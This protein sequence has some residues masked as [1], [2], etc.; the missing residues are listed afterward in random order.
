MN[1]KKILVI[2]DSEDVRDFCETLLADKYDLTSVSSAKKGLEKIKNQT[3]DAILLDLRI[4]TEDGLEILPEIKKL[5]P[6]IPV[7]MMTSFTSSFYQQEA[8]NLGA[9]DYLVKPFT[10]DRLIRALEKLWG[11]KKNGK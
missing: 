2:D 11:D 8:T 1:K 4:G 5:V 10:A 7:I 9:Q 3:Y 6:D